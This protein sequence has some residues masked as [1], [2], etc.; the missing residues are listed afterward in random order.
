M[1]LACSI[2]VQLQAQWGQ[3]K[4]HAAI[5]SFNGSTTHPPT[6]TSRTS[7]ELIGKIIK[8]SE[9]PWS[10]V[11]A[12]EY[13]VLALLFQSCDSRT[14]SKK[15]K[16]SRQEEGNPQQHGIY[17]YLSHAA[18]VEC[19]CSQ[20]LFINHK[21]PHDLTTNTLTWAYKLGHFQFEPFTL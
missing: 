14:S 13:W 1:C 19:F 9:V 21:H 5:Y 10:E 16:D 17:L 6:G 3:K 7:P 18:T 8:Y 20:F 4:D 15:A 12:A 2:A 11:P